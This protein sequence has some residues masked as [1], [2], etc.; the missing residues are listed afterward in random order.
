MRIVLLQLC[1]FIST[2]IYSHNSYFSFAEMQYN[3]QSSCLEISICVSTHD[4]DFYFRQK[5][6]DIRLEKAMENDSLLKKI[7]Q[8]ITNGFSIKQGGVTNQLSIEAYENT[9][10]GYT[11]FYLKSEPIRWNEPTS[12]TYDLFMD[13]FTEQQQKLTVLGSKNSDTYPFM[14]FQREQTIKLN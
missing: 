12:V 2:C 4:L 7:N 3:Q 1:L 10:D 8:L 13:L 9:L 14:L 5:V 11:F 6:Q